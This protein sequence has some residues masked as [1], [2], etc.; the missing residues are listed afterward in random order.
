MNQ[1]AVNPQ[2][3][4]LI[5]IKMPVTNLV[6]GI[7]FKHIAVTVDLYRVPHLSNTMCI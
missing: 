6:T 4:D 1:M 7:L 5:N 3:I 2:V